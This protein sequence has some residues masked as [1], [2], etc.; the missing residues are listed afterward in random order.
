MNLNL[1]RFAIQQKC[2]TVNMTLFQI[3]LLVV[4]KLDVY[5]AT[6]IVNL[7]GVIVQMKQ[8]KLGIGG[9]ANDT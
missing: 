8:L 3:V 9:C 4:I 5:V 1:A 6:H 7:C 2:S